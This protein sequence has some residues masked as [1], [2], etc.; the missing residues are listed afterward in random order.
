[1]AEDRAPL[2]TTAE[3]E[4]SQAASQTLTGLK[5]CWLKMSP[6]LANFSR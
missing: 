4:I 5:S 1:L 2:T 3:A 6:T